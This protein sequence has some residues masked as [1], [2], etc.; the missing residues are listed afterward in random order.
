ML[1]PP[2]RPAVLPGVVLRP[3]RG[4]PV[5]VAPQGV[6]VKK[7]LA[8][9]SYLR[10]LRSLTRRLKFAPAVPC[11]LCAV[12]SQFSSAVRREG[13]V[14]SR[15]LCVWLSLPLSQVHIK[16]HPA[17]TADRGRAPASHPR[18][19]SANQL[20]HARRR[21]SSSTRTSRECRWPGGG[22]WLGARAAA[23]VPCSPGGIPARLIGQR[24]VCTRGTRRGWRRQREA[25]AR[26]ALVD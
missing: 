20:L 22:R 24:T 15:C 13:T 5:N 7:R 3:H 17:T 12:P 25:R 21:E 9:L 18:R 4:R 11:S 14:M 8:P 1:V 19:A 23:A 10:Y 6:G 2:P 16:S 26:R